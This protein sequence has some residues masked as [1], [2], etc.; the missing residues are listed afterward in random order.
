M[1]KFEATPSRDVVT[2]KYHHQ[3]TRDMRQLGITMDM[4]DRTS[5]VVTEISAT[6]DDLTILCHA[7]QFRE[8]ALRRLALEEPE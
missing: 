3:A 6:S 8:V 4:D 2:R 1:G 5:P 7:G